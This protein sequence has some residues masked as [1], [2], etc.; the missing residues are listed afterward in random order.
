MVVSCARR[1]SPAVAPAAWPVATPLSL[2]GTG[3]FSLA[4][5]QHS[6]LWTQLIRVRVKAGWEPCSQEWFFGLIPQE[7]QRR[8]G[9]MIGSLSGSPPASPSCFWKARSLRGPGFPLKGIWT[10]TGSIAAEISHRPDSTD[11]GL[12]GQN[13]PIVSQLAPLSLTLVKT[14]L[15]YL[16]LR[17]LNYTKIGHR[18]GKEEVLSWNNFIAS[19]SYKWVF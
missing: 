1:P 9:W 7:A 13:Y 8:Q 4:L 19:V 18:H 6:A 11:L 5:L 15:Y 12:W 16:F 2:E 17:N 14:S 3:P 10:L